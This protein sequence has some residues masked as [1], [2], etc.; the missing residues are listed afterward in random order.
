MFESESECEHIP[1][2]IDERLHLIAIAGEQLVKSLLSLEKIR[3]KYI[4]SLLSVAFAS[5]G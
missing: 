1:C 2:A 3:G 5:S 4:L